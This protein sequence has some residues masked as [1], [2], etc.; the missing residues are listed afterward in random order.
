MEIMFSPGIGYEKYGASQTV[1]LLTSP[2][3]SSNQYV[4]NSDT[5]DTFVAH[6]FFGKN[7]Y[8]K[9]YLTARA[10]L[11]LGFVDDVR[12]SG[13]VNEFALPEF[14][15]LDY[16][17]NIK[18]FSAMATTYLSFSFSEL[19]QPYFNGGIGVSSNH[20]YGYKET[21]RIFG[22][23]PMEPY[24]NDTTYN[25]AYSLG[26]G[27]MCVVSKQFAL[28]LGYQFSDFGKASL[29]V[30]PAQETTQTLHANPV[31]LQQLLLNVSWRI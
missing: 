27:L 24:E 15:N 7:I 1:L 14:N 8:T 30:S 11:T 31:Q 13:V 3:E 20:A 9:G 4:E 21:P 2:Q 29:G 25:F 6:L 19:W 22:A 28:G 16:Q 26:L 18:T 5:Q 23:F 12:V 10:G 17:F